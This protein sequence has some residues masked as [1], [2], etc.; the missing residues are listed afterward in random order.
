MGGDTT[1]EK[2]SIHTFDNFHRVYV[3]TPHHLPQVNNTCP[4]NGPKPCVLQALSV[5]ENYYNRL[6]EF[7]T[8]YF[9]HAAEEQKA[10]ILSRQNIQ[11]HSGHVNASFDDLD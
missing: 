6:N 4:E 9:P 8:G 1:D 7:D 10:K 2:V 11:W 5:T 3:T